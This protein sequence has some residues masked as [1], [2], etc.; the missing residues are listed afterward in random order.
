MVRKFA[1]CFV[2]SLLV[3]LAGCHRGPSIT[4]RYKVI[5][6]VPGNSLGGVAEFSGQDDYSFE[7]REK[8]ASGKANGKYKVKDGN[9]STTM[10]LKNVRIGGVP[11]AAMAPFKRLLVMINRPRYG[12]IEWRND[13]E[14]VWR[15]KE[16][17]STFTR[18]GDNEF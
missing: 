1:A 15:T 16:G 18:M 17:M 14:F 4:G 6:A 8:G 5:F 9:L 11:A 13:N 2:V 12:K 7:L 3:F 10:S